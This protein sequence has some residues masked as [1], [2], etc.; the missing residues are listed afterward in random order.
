MKSAVDSNTVLWGQT[1]ILHS[2]CPKIMALMARFAYNI[3]RAGPSKIKPAVFYAFVAF[4]VTTGVS[5]HIITYNA[6]P[7][8]KS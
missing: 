5:L 3:V 2:V 4:L 1:I 7:W 8:T 6:I